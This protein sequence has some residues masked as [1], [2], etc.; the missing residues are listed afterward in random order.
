MQALK[1]VGEVMD[2]EQEGFVD[3]FCETPRAKLRI[4]AL[5]VRDRLLFLDC[6]HERSHRR[7]SDILPREGYGERAYDAVILRGGPEFRAV[8]ESDLALVSRVRDI[9]LSIVESSK[10]AR[11]R[12]PR[13]IRPPWAAPPSVTISLDLIRE[14]ETWALVC[15][16]DA[17]LGGPDEH[18]EIASG[19]HIEHYVRVREMLSDV[20]DV[21]RLADWVLPHVH[22]DTALLGDR[23]S[24]IPLVQAIALACLKRFGWDIPFATLEP[25]PRQDYSSPQTID[26]LRIDSS[27]LLAV[28]GVD[29]M[30]RH[31]QEL[32][33]LCPIEYKAVCLVDISPEE[34]MSSHPFRHHPIRRWPIKRSGQ[35]EECEHRT[36]LHHV[37]PRTEDKIP[38]EPR[39][40]RKLQIKLLEEHKAFWQAVDRTSA[41]RLHSEAPYD[42]GEK[43]AFRHRA[44]DLDV[45]A[46]L[47]DGAFRSRCRDELERLPRPDLVI[48]PK[49]DATGILEA[50]ARETF[51]ECKVIHVS[52]AQLDDGGIDAL[53][54][55]SNVL[56]LDDALV[57]GQTLRTLTD[58]V[59]VALG[60]RWESVHCVAF[61]AVS[62][63][64]RSAI[65]QNVENGLRRGNTHERAL[66]YGAR[67]LLPAS[68]TAACSFC[69]EQRWLSSMRAPLE[70]H[71]ELI[72]ARIRELGGQVE[73]QTLLFGGDAR[74]STTVSGSVLGA[75]MSV[76]TVFA[77]FSSAAQEIRDH[78]ATQGLPLREYFDLAHA[79][80]NWFGA[81]LLAGVLR[82]L[83]EEEL[84][85]VYASR[86]LIDVLGRKQF[87]PRELSELAWAAV[88]D[89]LPGGVIP[90]LRD[91]LRDNDDDRVVALMNDAMTMRMRRP[92]DDGALAPPPPPPATRGEHVPTRAK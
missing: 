87:D 2:A 8:V 5:D 55:V 61:V 28:L 49:H 25:W 36:V 80:E 7:P 56:L 85:Y 50:V 68:G 41:V 34:A 6:R 76:A 42:D 37:D 84:G 39:R 27:Q 71:R 26:D 63:P 79:V 57:T 14:I 35:C 43:R 30:G 29:S 13:L 45:S 67:I 22:K 46:L 24:L 83:G 23:P 3:F 21:E 54:S 89:K 66:R 73:P 77:A 4:P 86:E 18:F 19:N 31:E 33:M 70:A 32:A 38:S 62:S 74:G 91:L 12:G 44:L 20:L 10:D 60:R 16:R 15:S 1:E 64:A 17:L 59:R 88:L 92:T 65:Q 82:T 90:Q 11:H 75:R 81:P 52:R 69:E 48:I 53:A 9:P 47:V 51:E 40:A 78:M 72:D 58:N